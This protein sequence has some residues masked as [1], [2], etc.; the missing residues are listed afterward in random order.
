MKVTKNFIVQEFIYPELYAEIC[1]DS[2]TMM[3]PA[4]YNI[5]QLLRDLVGKPVTINNWNTGGSYKESGLR[6]PNT[7]TGAKK[8]A[9]KSG[10][11]IDCKIKGMSSYEM[12]A[13]V[14][15]NWQAFK[16]AGL[17]EIENPSSTEGKYN[18]WLHLSCRATG[19]ET[20]KIINP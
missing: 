13:I 15:K 2:A 9:H 8:S 16:S 10:E 20:L 3:N 7:K 12:A 17:T 14:Q 6:S 18:D 11:A 19:L 5:A 4:I 1:D